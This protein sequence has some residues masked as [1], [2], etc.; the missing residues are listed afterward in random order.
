MAGSGE[1][2]RNDNG[3]W[4]FR[5]KAANGQ[6]VAVDG[7]QGYS[8]KRDARSTL[9]R[10]LRGD[11]NGPIVDPATHVCGQ[12]IT[13]ST[14]LDADV[15]CTTGPAFIIAAD[16]VTL[17]LGGHTVS[18]DAHSGS[19]GPG[20]LFRN[21]SGS[22]VRNGTV[23]RFDAGVVVSGGS[24][25]T[26]LN[27]TAQDNV[28]P[29]DGEL[30][31]GIVLDSSSDN[32]IQGNTVQRNGPFSGIS[33]VNACHNNNVRGNIVKD[34]NMMQAGD[35]SAGRQDMGIRLE[36]P[37]A[38]NNDVVSNTVSGSGAEGISVHAGCLDFNSTPPCAGTPPNQQNNISKNTSS[39]NGTSGRG[40]G[41]KVFSMP[42][43]VA[44]TRNTITDNVTDDNTSYG[45]SVDGN[46]N[47]VG[48][49]ENRTSRNRAHG[50]RVFDGH[51]GNTATPCDAN[52]W[53]ANDFGTV[54]QPCVAGRTTAAESGMPEGAVAEGVAAGQSLPA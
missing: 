29:Q 36:G 51:D 30:G 44:P 45:I 10:L 50:N 28:G 15:L 17:D 19:R 16:N 32:R 47:G 27:I 20:I 52:V 53:T 35:P 21:V 26:V 41:I 23:Q 3:R 40:S 6:V 12:E 5:V 2:V 25:N 9:Q 43:A 42:T 34:N 8:S 1:L 13:K 38:S 33:L 46:P 54:N 31:D 24:K 48:A 4:G 14:K 49:T 11:Y 18:G 22:T 37:D 39:H 7:S